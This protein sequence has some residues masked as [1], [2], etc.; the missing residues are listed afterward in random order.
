[1]PTPRQKATKKSLLSQLPKSA[2]N[3]IT[4]IMEERDGKLSLHEYLV[5]YWDLF[6]P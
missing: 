4:K 3:Q 6:A 1:M 5:K 2:C